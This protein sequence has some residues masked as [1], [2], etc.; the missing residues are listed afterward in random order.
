MS[1]HIIVAKYHN[2]AAVVQLSH[3]CCYITQQAQWH[4]R[5]V[6]RG[7]SFSNLSAGN[8]ASEKETPT[9]WLGGEEDHGLW[10]D[11]SS[12]QPIAEN[13]SVIESLLIIYMLIVVVDSSIIQYFES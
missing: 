11:V 5:W 7:F 13:R 3:W 10:A 12:F 6:R 4:N 1:Q 9:S 8:S 2:A